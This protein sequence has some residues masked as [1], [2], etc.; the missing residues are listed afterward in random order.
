MSFLAFPIPVKIENTLHEYIQGYEVEV[1]IEVVRGF[2]QKFQ[3]TV[4]LIAWFRAS[5]VARLD[6]I[7]T[8]NTIHITSI[9]G[10]RR[11][12]ATLRAFWI[13]LASRSGKFRIMLTS[14]LQLVQHWSPKFISYAKVWSLW[15]YARCWHQAGFNQSLTPTELA[16]V[17]DLLKPACIDSKSQTL[18]I[19]YDLESPTQCRRSQ[20]STRTEIIVWHFF[21]AHQQA[22]PIRLLHNILFCRRYRLQHHI[23]LDKQ[24][25][26]IRYLMF[27]Y[28]FIKDIWNQR[29]SFLF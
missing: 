19:R 9:H 1:T 12:K 22:L 15:V 27:N 5:C 25:C 21:A 3:N 13:F 10:A 7:I 26:C 14:V 29:F 11:S 28:H 18:C 2:D 6:H 16:R 23:H 4:W 24:W 20:V 17:N 8:P